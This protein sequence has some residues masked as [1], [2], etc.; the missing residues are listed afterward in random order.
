MH[1]TRSSYAPCRS[2]TG[3]WASTSPSR[4]ATKRSAM[5][6]ARRTFC[7][8]MRTVLPSPLRRWMARPISATNTGASPPEGSSRSKSVG[9]PIR[10]R[11]RATICCSPPDIERTLCRRRR[12]RR[13]KRS[14]ARARPARASPRM[15]APSCRLSSTVMSGKRSRAWETWTIPRRNVRCGGWPAMSCPSRRMRPALGRMKP[16]IV[17]RAGD[18]PLPFAPSRATISP[19]RTARSTP[20]RTWMGPYPATRLSTARSG[21]AASVAKVGFQHFAIPRHLRGRSV[22]DDLAVVEH[23]D[24]VRHRH[25]ELDRVLDEDDGD[26]FLPHQPADDAEQL[27]ADGRR[28]PDGGLVEEKERRA[29]GGRAHD[30]DHALLPARQLAGGLVGEMA[31]AH[32]LE[33]PAG[34]ARCRPLGRAGRR[35]AEQHSEES[36]GD[37]RVE[38]GEHGLERGALAEEPAVLEGAPDALRGHQVGREAGDSLPA[39]ADGAGGQHR[40]PRDRVEERRLAGAVRPDD[41]A[42]PA[43]VEAQGNAGDGGEPAVPHGDIVQLEEGH[44]YSRED[45]SR[46]TDQRRASR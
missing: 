14:Y 17:F 35:H 28:Q 9:S 34:A 36:R 27:L 10:A 38:T 46:K 12:A 1:R 21:G 13:G 43:G 32:E 41:R 16:L 30:L 23:D 44:G 22:G 8:T 15:A 31:D 20:R 24:P 40:V 2:L 3:P 11:P 26:P 7:S 18:L 42:H 4:S 39:E 5:A 19:R 29:R 6:R 37:L 45:R 25:D 33:E